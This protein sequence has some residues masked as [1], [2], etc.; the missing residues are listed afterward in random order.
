LCSLNVIN[1]LHTG[2]DARATQWLR[3]ADRAIATPT[4]VGSH[5]P[6]RGWTEIL[7]AAV[8]RRP[9]SELIPICQTGLTHLGGGPWASFGWWTL[10][11][12]HFLDGDPA[13]AD[14]ALQCGLFEAELAETPLVA[15]HCLATGAIIDDCCG[16]HSRA[17]ERGLQAADVLRDCHGETLPPTAPV[18]AMRALLHARHGEGSSALLRIG[19]ARR[20]LEGFRSVS[21][22]FNVITRIALVRATLL[23]D[24]REASRTL[25]RELEHH[26]RLESSSGGAAAPIRELRARVDAMHRPATGASALTDAELAVLR[27]LPTNLSLAKIADG[28]FVSRNTVK[29]H[30]AAIYRKLGASNR[31]EAVERARAAGLLDDQQVAPG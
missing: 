15:A 10:G 28:L 3:L 9:A 2:D 16:D 22:W 13:M 21:P 26:A 30:T 6:M 24:D 14:K 29:S 11:A 18:M 27:H 4:T 12:L 8:D 5:D 1:A 31:T 23:L 17:A 20:A 19:A 7:H 25:M